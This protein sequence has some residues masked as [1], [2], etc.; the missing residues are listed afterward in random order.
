[1]SD[2]EFVK[3]E[4]NWLERE[5]NRTREEM[6]TWPKW[7]QDEINMSKTETAVVT[8]W[9]AGNRLDNAAY[10][11]ELHGDMGQGYFKPDEPSAKKLSSVGHTVY[12]YDARL[13]N[14]RDEAVQAAIKFCHKN[15]VDYRNC[16]LHQESNIEALQA[17]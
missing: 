9:V 10:V 15:I 8:R 5:I 6:K 1:M 4:G 3:L 12:V 11:I 16:I 17:L 7:V 2:L 14:T 13:C